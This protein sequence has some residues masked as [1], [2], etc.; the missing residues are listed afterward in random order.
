VHGQQRP[1]EAPV[2]DLEPMTHLIVD[3]LHGLDLNIPKVAMKYSILDPA[4]LTSDMREACAE[5]FSEIGCSLDCRE[6]TERDTSKKWFHGSVWHY[7]FMLGANHKSYGLYANIFQL[8]L[9]VYGIKATDA[10]S[11]SAA[12]KATATSS[13]TPPARK[14]PAASGIVDDFSDSEGESEDE[15]DNDANLDADDIMAELTKFFGANAARVKLILKLWNA[16]ADLFNALCDEW[17][18]GLQSERDERAYQVLKSSAALLDLLNSV[19]N[20]RHKCAYVQMM[21]TVG[22]KQVR[23]RGNLWPFSTRA[24]EGRGGQLKKIGRRIICWRRRSQGTYKR[25]IRRKGVARTVV[26]GYG[27]APERQLMRASCF[28]EDRTHTQKRSRV[29]TTGRNTLARSTPKAELAELP[30][31]GDALETECVK[32][33]CRIERKSGP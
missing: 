15:D 7:D 2:T 6:K 19:S 30:A 20:R 13:S 21:M 11:A 16:Y 1:F 18:T 32:R 8:C 23:Q 14:R 3:L 5:F 10:T 17:K 29:V 28:R 24:V 26:Q 12:T 9:I 4:L 22:A 31:M 33:L 25:N 27:S